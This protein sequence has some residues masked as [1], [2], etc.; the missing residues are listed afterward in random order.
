MINYKALDE[1]QRKTAARVIL[2]DRFPAL[3]LIGGVDQAYFNHKIISCIT[4]LDYITLEVKAY[5]IAIDEVKFPYIPSYLYFREG[6]VIIKAYNKL[7]IKPDVLIIDGCGVNHPRRAGLASHVGVELDISTIGVS[8]SILCGEI[9]SKPKLE[10]EYSYIMLDGKE[11]A[12]LLLS[13]LNCRPIVVAPGNKVSL[14]SAVEI[15]KNCLRGH[16]LPEPLRLAHLF[17]NEAKRFE[18][19]KLVGKEKVE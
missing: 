3:K 18:I 19:A 8:K 6:S 11:A 9:Q 2:R 15:V 5:S 7:R 12:V 4:V 16:K 14:K 17:A 13:K 10:G 1:I